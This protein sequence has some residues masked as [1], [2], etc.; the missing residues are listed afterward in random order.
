MMFSLR[1]SVYTSCFATTLIKNQKLNSPNLNNKLVY[2]VSGFSHYLTQPYLKNFKMGRCG[3]LV[4]C[5]FAGL[6]KPTTCRLNQLYAGKTGIATSN[7]LVLLLV[8][9]PVAGML[10][11]RLAGIW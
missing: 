3:W 11:Y 8:P 9:V 2:F 4:G 5:W 10:I 1:N 7:L 6:D